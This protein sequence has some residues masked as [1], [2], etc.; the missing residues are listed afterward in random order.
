ME[1]NF[2]VIGLVSPAKEI[3][4]R[5]QQT[6]VLAPAEINSRRRRRNLIN[7]A[8]QLRIWPI[9]FGLLKIENSCHVSVQRQVGGASPAVRGGW[10]VSSSFGSQEPSAAWGEGGE[11]RL[12]F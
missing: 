4:H 9:W 10:L 7:L 11:K 12:L 2:L 5:D 6:V 3:V 1:N 8:V